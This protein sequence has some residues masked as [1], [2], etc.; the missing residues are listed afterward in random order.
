MTPSP[1]TV[2][3]VIVLQLVNTPS[4]YD[5]TASR[6]GGTPLPIHLSATKYGL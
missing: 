6:L 5:V 1:A 2:P 3:Y 4:S